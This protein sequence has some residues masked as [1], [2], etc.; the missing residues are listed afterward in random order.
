MKTM[1]NRNG[2]VK[3]KKN[4]DFRAI[5]VGPGLVTR[6]G[7]TGGDAYLTQFKN[8]VCDS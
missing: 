5:E 6:S 2:T 1:R 7:V 4:L 8:F 3:L